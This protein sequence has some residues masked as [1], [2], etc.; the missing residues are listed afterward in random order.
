MKSLVKFELI[1]GSLAFALIFAAGAAGRLAQMAGVDPKT[2]DRAV[3]GS[4]FLFFC[5]FG[6]CA[7]GLMVHVFV[8][9]QAGIGNGN[10]PMVRF[11]AQHETGLVLGA[12]G[13]LGMGA[14]IAAPFVLWQVAGPR[15]RPSK[16][17]LEADIGMTMAEVRQRSTVPWRAPT[18]MPDGSEM[19][20]EDMVFDYRLG[21]PP[22]RFP[23][24]RYFW[25]RTAPNGR[26]ADMNIGITPEKLPLKEM[27]AFELDARRR[28]FSA[29]W[30]PGHFVADS[31]ETVRMWGGKRTSQDGRYWLKNDTVVSF[32]R[33]RMDDEQPN[34]PPGSGEFVVHIHL[35]PKADAR[36]VVFEPSAW[37]PPR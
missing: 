18:H 27:E 6:F 12:W 31:E 34:E 23:Q 9:L 32:E 7:I 25:L 22:V 35:E 37:Q 3:Y 17:A 2:A 5:V 4:I 33:Q 8:A 21:T 28:L 10:T 14:L 13:F 11:L 29:G 15:T 19:L 1:A 26:L 30:M 20:V 16:G 36:D 24:S